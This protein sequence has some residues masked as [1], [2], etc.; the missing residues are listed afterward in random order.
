M[1]KIYHQST[2][3]RHSSGTG[4]ERESLKQWEIEQPIY[5]TTQTQ[6]Y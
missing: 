1:S 6:T 4:V 2:Q 3:L 5:T